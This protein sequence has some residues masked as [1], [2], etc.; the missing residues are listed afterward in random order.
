M[1]AYNKGEH[2]RITPDLSAQ[3]LKARKARSS[4]TQALRMNNCQPRILY[5]AKLSFSL[6]GEIKTFQDKDRL[7]QFMST[8]PALQMILKGIIIMEVNEKHHK[9]EQLG[10]NKTQGE[11]INLQELGKQQA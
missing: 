1:P 5:P 6:E 3:A 7:Q 4:K 9:Y 11:V 2:M 10:K 8:K